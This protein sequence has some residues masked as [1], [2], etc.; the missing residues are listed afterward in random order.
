M[1]T[2]FGDEITLVAANQ[3]TL[4]FSG[5]FSKGIHPKKNSIVDAIRWFENYANVEVRY[6]ISVQKNI[7]VMA[8]LGGGTADAAAI[9]EILCA[10]YKIKK[11]SPPDLAILGADVPVSFYGA[12]ARMRGI[13]EKISPWALDRALYLVL[14][15]PHKDVETKSVFNAPNLGNSAAINVSTDLDDLW[16]ST[17]NDMEDAACEI[18]PEIVD[19][20]NVLTEFGARYV[21][22]TG[23]GSTVFAICKDAQEAARLAQNV[24]SARPEYWLQ[25][26]LVEQGKRGN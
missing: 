17:K 18:C 9:I 10:Q 5:P 16:N 19:I 7:P 24:K 1:F 3:L 2:E 12:P 25:S 26:A 6:H 4:V 11:P 14:V 8:G 23:S 20:K 13:G 15:N 22:M 21:R